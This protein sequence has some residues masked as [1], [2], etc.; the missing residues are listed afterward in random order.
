M[1]NTLRGKYTVTVYEEV[2]YELSTNTAAA[3]II[4]V[5]VDPSM[6]KLEH[7]K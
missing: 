3:L 2:L 6:H 1:A 4:P 5:V 7:P